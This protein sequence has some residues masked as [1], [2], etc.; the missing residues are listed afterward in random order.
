M[1]NIEKE[2]V[3]LVGDEQYEANLAKAEEFKDLGNKALLKEELFEAIKLYTQ[4]INVSVETPKNAIYYANRANVHLKLENFGLA[5]SDSE[6]AIKVDPKY[7]KSYFRRAIANISLSRWKNAIIDLK[8]ILALGFGSEEVDTKLA[9]CTKEYKRERFLASLSTDQG[10]VITIEKLVE[11]NFTVQQGYT[12][13]VYEGR[14]KLTTEW[15]QELMGNLKNEKFIAKK[16]LVEMLQDAKNI[17]VNNETFLDV[18]IPD[19]EV[20]SVC[21]DIHGQFYDLLNIFVVNGL[22]SESNPYLFNGDFVDRGAFSVECVITLLAWKLLLPNKFFLA[23]G[24]HETKNINKMYGYVSNKIFWRIK[25][26]VR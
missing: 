13:Q 14:Q 25:G 12:G 23:R 19:E 5:I 16:Y 18:E 20:F 10:S 22:P 3:Y 8:Q 11:K 26:K 2:Y 21:G 4:A 9:F 17:L 7:V 24:N 15:V 1:D 6:N